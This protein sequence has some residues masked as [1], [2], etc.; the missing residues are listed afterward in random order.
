MR[1]TELF[2]ETKGAKLHVLCMEPDDKTEAVLQIVH[3]MQ[4]YIGRYEDF[5]H[6]LCDNHIAVVG[7]DHPGHGLTSTKEDLGYFGE[8]NGMELV[9]SLIHI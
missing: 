6:F 9:L 5:A 1:R 8:Q 4:E 7:H 3:G 2:L